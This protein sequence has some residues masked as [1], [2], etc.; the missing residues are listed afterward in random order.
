MVSPPSDALP[1]VLQPDRVALLVGLSFFLGLAFEGFYTAS[2]SSRPGGIRTFPLLAVTGAVLYAL[3]ATHLVPFTVG[4]VVLGAWMHA[5]YR[6]EVGRQG[7]ESEPPD[8]IMVPLC[9]VIAFTLGPVALT[10]PTWFAIGVTVLTVLLLRAREKLHTLAHKIPSGEILTLVQFLTLTGIV[11]PLLPREPV[12][13]VTSLTPFQVW[14]A[15]VVVCAISYAS[16]LMRRFVSPAKSVFF[17]AVLGGM[18]SSTATTVVLSRSM[19]SEPA[20]LDEMQSGVVLATA[21]MYVRVGLVVAIFNPPLALALAP[22]L[23]GL[24]L[25]GCGMAAGILG[26][27]SRRHDGQPDAVVHPQNPLELGTAL[28]FALLFIVVSVVT[29]WIVRRF[30][31]VGAYGVAAVVGVTDIDP[32]VL[33]VAHGGIAGLDLRASGVAILIATSSNNL[34][35]AGYVFAFAGRRAAWRPLIG[36]GVLA[37][38]GLAAAL[39]A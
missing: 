39:V 22:W 18:Y 1:A 26:R 6:T 8:G 28:V 36:L 34:L 10:Q 12:V 11:L 20:S 16:Y 24:S 7:P 23:A 30:G 9:N 21:I 38:A 5:H 32:F 19:R 25:L 17:A 37:A 2:R 33:S 15:V 4:L 29:T 27:R 31:M 3:E 13:T 35:K 14:L